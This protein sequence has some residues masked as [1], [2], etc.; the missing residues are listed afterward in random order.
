M[1]GLSHSELSLRSVPLKICRG[2]LKICKGWRSSNPCGKHSESAKEVVCNAGHRDGKIFI[3]EAGMLTAAGAPAPFCL[4]VLS[5]GEITAQSR[6]R[7]PL[8]QRQE[9]SKV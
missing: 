3:T 9:A 1:D 8:N 2:R 5:R 6:V 4:I 7:K